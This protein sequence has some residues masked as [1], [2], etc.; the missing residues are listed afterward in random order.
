MWWGEGSLIPFTHPDQYRR[1]QHDLLCAHDITP[2]T[3]YEWDGDAAMDVWSHVRKIK[4]EN[5][6]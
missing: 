3:R 6:I 1:F 5:N 4:S 2:D